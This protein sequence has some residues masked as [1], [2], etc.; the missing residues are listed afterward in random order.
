MK[1]IQYGCGLSAPAQWTNYDS[2]LSLRLQKIPL[3]GKYVPSGPFGRF[4]SNVLIGD[5]VKGLPEPTQ[6]ADLV[7]CSHI[8]EHLT[9]EEFRI[10]L[11][12]T[13]N[14]LKPGGTFRF[15]LPDLEAKAKAYINSTDAEAIHVF[16]EETYLGKKSRNNSIKG[17]LRDLFRNDQHLWMWDYKSMKV[18][19]EKVGFVNVR[20]A[21][22]GDS[23]IKDFS[24]IEENS[25]WNNELGV[26][27]LKNMQG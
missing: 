10:A 17:K 5:I 21:Q 27:C 19:L 6:C 15:V 18:E 25:R 23:Q 8:L 12:N 4:P 22:F 14:L 9:L 7:Y 16:M 13:Y 26:E 3:I 24:E 2:S 11:K 1:K 20:R